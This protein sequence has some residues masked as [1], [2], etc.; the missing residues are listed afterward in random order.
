MAPAVA[1]LAVASLA[2]CGS[3]EVAGVAGAAQQWAA[4]GSDTYSVTVTSSCGERLLIGTFDVHVVG[5]VVTSVEGL[6]EPGRRA[7][8]V[9]TVGEYVPTVTSLLSRLAITHR[10]HAPEV[11]FDP[12]TGMPTHV[13]LDP[14]PGSLDDQECYDFSDYSPGAA[15]ASS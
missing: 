10:E 14:L 12:A 2:G 4:R 15:A 7:A 8:Q 13:V 6:D 3:A 1:L 9:A 5:G 11:M